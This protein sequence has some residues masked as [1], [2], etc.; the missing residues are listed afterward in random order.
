[1]ARLIAVERDERQ[2]NIRFARFPSQAIA[3]RNLNVLVVS[4]FSKGYLLI[5]EE[6]I[7]TAVATLR[8]LGFPLS[9]EVS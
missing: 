6:S 2:E 3:A 5:R 8:K 1:M 7:E 4:T 9:I